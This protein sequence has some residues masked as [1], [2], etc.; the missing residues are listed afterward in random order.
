[1]HVDGEK[2]EVLI[3][4]YLVCNKFMRPAF[5]KAPNNKLWVAIIEKLWAKI[6]G[7]YG[8]IENGN[9]CTTLRDLT[10]AP[11]ITY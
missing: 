8:S 3:D 7:S 5:S 4:D 6:H 10:G 1:M 11:T 2:K 9:S